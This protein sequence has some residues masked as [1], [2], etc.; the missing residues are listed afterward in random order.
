MAR[1]YKRDSNGRFAGGGGGGSAGKRGT[2]G[3]RLGGRGKTIAVQSRRTRAQQ[4]LS[5]V[6]TFNQVRKTVNALGRKGWSSEA[7]RLSRQADRV[8]SNSGLRRVYRTAR[9]LARAAR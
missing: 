9:G 3:A 6:G 7:D 1:T 4:K 2:A 5:Q 8:G